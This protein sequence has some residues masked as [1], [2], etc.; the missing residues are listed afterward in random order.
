[1]KYLIQTVETYRVDKEDE[2]KRMIEEA[3]SDNHF[4]LK[5]YSSEYKEKKQKGEI[6]DTYYKVTLTKAF[7][8]EKE[9]EFRTEIS[10]ANDIE[11]A[12]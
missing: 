3:K 5:K 9:P 6:I 1:M 8:D 10:Y 7:T 11:S 12:F 2:A 4:I